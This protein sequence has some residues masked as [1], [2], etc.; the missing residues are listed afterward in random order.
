MQ[1]KLKIAYVIRN[2]TNL[3]FIKILINNKLYK[4][5]SLFLMQQ[6]GWLSVDRNEVRLGF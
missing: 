3:N 2:L 1:Q 4:N 6:K 5:K